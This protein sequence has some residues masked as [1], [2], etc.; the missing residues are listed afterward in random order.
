[1][2]E[3][4]S[5]GRPEFAWPSEDVRNAD[6]PADLRHRASRIGRVVILAVLIAVTVC[7]L[8]SL[9][10]RDFEFQAKSAVLSEKDS[11][12]VADVQISQNLIRSV[13]SLN[14]NEVKSTSE[15]FHRPLTSAKLSGF[16]IV[17]SDESTKL[18]DLPEIKRYQVDPRGPRVSR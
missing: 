14:F 10:W 4:R 6:I 8:S 1:M 9:N 15:V 17:P 13:F 11:S 7:S 12:E 2:T 16:Q 5:W 18:W 3:M